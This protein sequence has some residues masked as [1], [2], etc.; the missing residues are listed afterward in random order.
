MRTVMQY[1]QIL[2]ICASIVGFCLFAGAFGVMYAFCRI[3]PYD[4]LGF[5]YKEIRL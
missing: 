4:V 5:G 2:S 1:S 3:V